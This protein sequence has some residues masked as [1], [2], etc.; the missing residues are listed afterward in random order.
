MNIDDILQLQQPL[1]D[2]GIRNVN[3]F[4]GRL[5]TAKDLSRE[6]QGRREAD[7][8]LGLAI[9]DGVAFGLQ[10]T[11]DADTDTPATPVL[12]VQ[13]GLAVNRAGQT[14]RLAADTRVALTRKFNATTTVDTSNCGCAFANCDPIA[15]GVYV[16]GA[17]VYVLTL[18]P[19]QSSEGRADSN[20]LDPSNVRCNTDATVDALQFRLLALNPQ[21]YADLDLASPLFRNRL[22]YRCFGIEAREQHVADPWRADPPSYGLIDE[23]RS[24]S[25]ALS[26]REVPLAILYW[27]AAGL[28]FVDTWAVRRALTAPDALD[29]GAF[30]ARRRRL[31]EAQAMCAQFQAHLADV[32]A[33]NGN[34]SGLRATDVFRY[35]PPFGLVPLQNP[36]L[37]GFGDAAFLTG[38]VRRPLPGSG[39]P[40]PFIDARMLGF[41]RSQALEAAAATDLTLKEFM[42]VYRPWQPVQA[43]SKGQTVQ[44]LLVFASGLL[45]EP[46][47]ARFDMGRADFGNFA[48]PGSTAP[49]SASLASLSSGSLSSGSVSLATGPTNAL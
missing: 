36:P 16:A 31:V 33:S 6:Q 10:A 9:G 21:R 15:D 38:V 12:R 1:A 4:N 35:L 5:L 29:S 7:S 41:L 2:G 13:A 23:L 27:T 14:L 26:D 40:T 8:R 45:P 42:W 43:M 37:R 18:A 34:P 39:Q 48:T 47:Y 28:Q 19:A 22:A 46:A 17:G 20:G 30:V 49:P 3:F 25:G 44:P 24:V 11:R 32:L